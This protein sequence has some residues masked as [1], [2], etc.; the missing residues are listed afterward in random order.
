MAGGAGEDLAGPAENQPLTS[1]LSPDNSQQ[2]RNTMSGSTC[3]QVIADKE[4]QE[5]E[6]NHGKEGYQ[7]ESLAHEEIPNSY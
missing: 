2:Y 7:E 6:T 5:K 4:K 1:L 3:S